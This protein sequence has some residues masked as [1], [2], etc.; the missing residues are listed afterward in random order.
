MVPEGGEERLLHEW[1]RGSIAAVECWSAAL[2]W[3]KHPLLALANAPRTCGE[4]SSEHISDRK[5][6]TVHPVIRCFYNT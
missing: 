2:C 3:S 1:V 4:A 5:S 6:V